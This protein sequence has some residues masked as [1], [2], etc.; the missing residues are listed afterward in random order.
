MSFARG[1]G[2]PE[3][4]G[5]LKVDM[6]N[7]KISKILG[8]GLAISMLTSL[9]A[10]GTPAS[11]GT[12]KW[13]GELGMPT[14]TTTN[15]TVNQIFGGSDVSKIATSGNT[16]YVINSQASATLSN[17][18]LKSLDGGVKFTP[19][20][21]VASATEMPTQIAVAPG[22]PNLIAVVS[23]NATPAV[24]LWYSNDGGTTFNL[25]TGHTMTTVNAVAISPSTAGTRYI[26]VAG[27][28]GGVADIQYIPIGALV[29]NWSM[30][31]TSVDWQ[32]AG[33][34]IQ[35]TLNVQSI[36]FSPNFASDKVLTA[37]TNN[38]T[39]TT[40]HLEIFSFATK[41]GNAAAGF[42]GYPVNILGTT[43]TAADIAL[44]P[45]Y[46]GADDTLRTAFIALTSGAAGGVFRMD[47]VT[48][49]DFGIAASFSSVDF[50][51]TDLVAGAAASNTVYYSA[52]ALAAIASVTVTATTSLQRP[53]AAATTATEVAWAGTNV[54]AGTTG[55]GSSFSVSKDKGVTFND[56]SLIDTT[57]GIMPD[58]AVTK[59]GT[60]VF[61]LTN[62]ATQTSLWRKTTVWERILN[63]VFSAGTNSAG[64][65]GYLLRLS[66]DAS[67]NISANIYLVNTAI[68][69]LDLYY[70]ADS[71]EKSWALKPNLLSTPVDLAVE[72]AQVA[73]ALTPTGAVSKTNNAGFTW[74][75]AI[76]TGL[77]NGHVIRSLKKDQLVVGGTAGGVAWT[78][79]GNLTV[80]SW[81]MTA[82]QPYTTGAVHVTGDKIETG[83]FLYVATEAS[84]TTDS[85]KRLNFG[86]ATWTD[87]MDQD[88]MGAGQGIEINDG[89]LY[90]V[91][92]FTDNTTHLHRTLTPGTATSTSN[93]EGHET[94]VPTLAG[95]TPTNVYSK[96]PQSF[97]VGGGKLWAI[98][99]T[100]ANRLDSFLDTLYKTAPTAS[101]PADAAAPVTNPV[102]GESQDMVFSWAKLSDTTSYNLEIALD[103]AFTQK[104]KT[105]LFTPVPANTDPVV[106]IV[107]RNQPA[108]TAYPFEPGTTYYWRVQ[109]KEPLDSPYTAARSFTFT[110]LEKPFALGGPAVGANDVSI[111][112]ILSWSEYKG[113]KW[114]EVTMSE[115]PTFAIPE[116]SHNVVGLVYGVVDPLK[117]GTTYYWRVRGVTADPFVQGTKVITPAGP[118]MTGAFT[119]MAE[120]TTAVAPT[121]PPPPQVIIST[122]PAPPPQVITVEKSVPAAIPEW[123]LLTII[124]IG[125]ILVVALIV[126][127]VRT[128]KVA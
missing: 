98:N 119:T 33:A 107:G 62:S 85:V 59:D 44:A 21:G 24:N 15:A 16:I 47:D 37:V 96:E 6:N 126:L 5:V 50:N 69:S 42:V 122:A 61:L 28:A 68:G 91:S 2:Q 13:D 41:R 55:A 72:S 128:R 100:A 26:T 58:V 77:G 49:R 65:P 97:K 90:V 84:G 64:S 108:L 8:L 9:L 51:G 76:A 83:G 20:T 10:V 75:T 73:Y 70:S 30:L 27:V 1:E 66:P 120:P 101:L 53:G 60:V 110:S 79:D 121:T 93:W 48:K 125:A 57:I 114:Y 116:W 46:L 99:N 80:T 43:S 109:A 54:V 39:S 115:D 117:Y 111:K 22:D 95:G 105:V 23:V 102:T 124:L 32:T 89:V 52:N 78:T 118:Y 40:T 36:A 7:S 112:P 38:A 18:L 103:A 88:V 67:N 86:A 19:L 74:E 31:A 82:T 4:K 29:A 12:L 34:P 81:K 35:G 56:I 17:N 104:V 87:I 106:A 123:M 45:T 113:A 127:I 63:P 92:L 14:T 94:A 25:L 11:A 71:G 3:Q